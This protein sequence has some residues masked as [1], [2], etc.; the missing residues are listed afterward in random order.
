[1]RQFPPMSDPKPKYKWP[2]FALAGVILFIVLA[3]VWMTV[4]VKKEERQTDFSAPL[5]ASAPTR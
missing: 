1:M 2:W 4:A 3:I 5:P